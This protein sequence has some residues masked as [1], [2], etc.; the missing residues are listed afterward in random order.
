MNTEH[1]LIEHLMNTESNIL[2]SVSNEELI[3]ECKNR[4]LYV[5]VWDDWDVDVWDMSLLDKWE[6]IDWGM[7]NTDKQKDVL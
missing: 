4:G 6:V 7:P 5:V 1:K 2:Q 3:K